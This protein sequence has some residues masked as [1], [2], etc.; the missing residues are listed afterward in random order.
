MGLLIGAYE[1]NMKFWAEDGTPLDFG[2]ELFPDDLDRIEENMLRAIARVPAVGAAGVKK[3]INGPMIWSPDSAALFGP[4]PELQQLFLLHRHHSGLLAVGRAS[5]KLAAE[6]MIE[7]E[8]SLDMFGWDL[9]RFG[10]WA[11]KAFTKAR[12]QDQYSHRFKIHFP[13]E[14][15]AAGRPVRTRPAYAMQKEIGGV[16]GLNYRLGA[17]AVVRCRGRAARRDHRLHPAELVGAGR[18]RS[19]H[20]ARQCRGHRHLQLRQICGEGPGSARPG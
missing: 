13:N 12:V 16:F 7:G 20:A 5:G 18:A 14:E 3:V 6:W 17:S 19:A 10:N 1:R 15:R 4:V 2:H 11:G 8:P 9:A